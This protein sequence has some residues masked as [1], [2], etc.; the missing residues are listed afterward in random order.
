MIKIDRFAD[1][2]EFIEF[3][4]PVEHP[5]LED[6]SPILSQEMVKKA[7]QDI[8]LIKISDYEF[9]HGSFWVENQI[10]GLIYFE[11]K[12]KGMAAISGPNMSGNMK[13]SRFTGHPIDN[14]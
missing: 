8:F 11:K 5:F 3:G 10:G 6:V 7:P 1:H 14:N 12:L 4:K 2:P 13:F 9:I